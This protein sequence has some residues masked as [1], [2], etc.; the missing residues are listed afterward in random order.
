M[1]LSTSFLSGAPE[2][3]GHDQGNGKDG[4]R[5]IGDGPR[6][7]EHAGVGVGLLQTNDMLLE[8]PFVR[9]QLRNPAC[10]AASPHLL[11]KR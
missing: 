1:R 9:G 8:I 6:A 2:R 4:G 7:Y 10:A 3:I 11:I 5:L